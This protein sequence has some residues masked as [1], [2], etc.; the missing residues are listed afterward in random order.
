M[1]RDLPAAF[2]EYLLQVTATPEQ[3]L[4]G[5]LANPPLCDVYRRGFEPGS[6]YWITS[7]GSVPG[8]RPPAWTPSTHANFPPVVRARVRAII[9]TLRTLERRVRTQPTQEAG[10]LILAW[11]PL[12]DDALHQILVLAVADM[13]ADPAVRQALRRVVPHLE[14]EVR[15]APCVEIEEAEEAGEMW[16]GGG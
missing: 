3:A 1:V 16:R 14:R 13:W 8:T 15:D 6:E 4:Y 5:T 12:P 11:Q 9:L 10:A 7:A 2:Q